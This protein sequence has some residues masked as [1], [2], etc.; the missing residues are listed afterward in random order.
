M[1]L[2]MGL[3]FRIR[4]E[5]SDVE[6]HAQ[7]ISGILAILGLQVTIRN[8]RHSTNFILRMA[9]TDMR[10]RSQPCLKRLMLVVP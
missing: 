7:K 8:T 5:F 3:H 4:N 1:R 6:G 2:E 9:N 10:K